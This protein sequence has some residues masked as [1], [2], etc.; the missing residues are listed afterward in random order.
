MRFAHVLG[1]SVCTLIFVSSSPLLKANDFVLF[2]DFGG[3]SA[4]STQPGYYVG[5]CLA[6]CQT[7]EGYAFDVQTNTIPPGNI[8][9]G[10]AAGNVSDKLWATVTPVTDTNGDPGF[11]QVVF[12]MDFGLDHGSPTSCASV[13]GCAFTADGS[14]DTLGVITWTDGFFPV[15]PG[16]FTTTWEFQ[17]VAPEPG[18]FFLLGGALAGIAGLRRRRQTR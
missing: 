11:T 18:T 13:G 16:G 15:G 12:F 1:L 2:Q 8:Y 9:I 6:T 10:D 17:F 5:G 14:V 4:L 3:F 7:E